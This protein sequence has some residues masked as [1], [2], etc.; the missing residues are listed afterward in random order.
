MGAGACFSRSTRSN[1]CSTNPPKCSFALSIT[2]L[3]AKPTPPSAAI[4]RSPRACLHAQALPPEAHGDRCCTRPPVSRRSGRARRLYGDMNKVSKRPR[5]L[6]TLLPALRVNR[7][8]HLDTLDTLC[9]CAQ[10][11]GLLPAKIEQG[12]QR[13]QKFG[14]PPVFIQC[15][16]LHRAGDGMGG[17]AMRPAYGVRAR[18]RKGRVSQSRRTE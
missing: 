16:S 3:S 10:G 1:C 13:I 7:S 14:G 12:V 2:L 15:I 17:T 6:D 8:C 4:G 5:N 11:H 9:R 18:L